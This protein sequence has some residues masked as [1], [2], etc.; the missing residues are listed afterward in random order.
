MGMIHHSLKL[1]NV[2]NK[3]LWKTDK[4]T[5]KWGNISSFWPPPRK[6]RSTT[7]TVEALPGEIVVEESRCHPHD[8]KHEQ[9]QQ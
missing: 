2:T 3:T 7:P 5:R 9:R 4:Q 1:I 6:L 8:A